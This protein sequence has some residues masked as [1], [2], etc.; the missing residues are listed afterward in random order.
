MTISELKTAIYQ[1][2]DMLAQQNMLIESKF[3]QVQNKITENQPVPEFELQS[4]AS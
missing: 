1:M 3:N 2:K 4:L